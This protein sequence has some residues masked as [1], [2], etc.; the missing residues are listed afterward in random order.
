MLVLGACGGRT[1]IID[2]VD[3]VQWNGV[4][5]LHVMPTTTPSSDPVLG[6]R[7]AT[8]R[9]RLADNETDPSH[10][11]Q[12]GEAAFLQAGTPIYS[13][14]DYR[15]SFR[16]GV[17]GATGVAIYEADT[18]SRA[19]TGADLL[20]LEGKVVQIT[21]GDSSERELAAIRDPSVVGHLVGLLLQAP[22]DQSVHAPASGP[23]Y[24][25]TIRFL[26]GTH[27]VRAFWPSTGELSRGILAGPDFAR[28][29]LAT[30]PSPAA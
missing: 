21:V 8:T 14:R 5:Y 1:A 6:A 29:I 26:D 19:R 3:F 28:A 23:Q 22:V 9:R 18:N 4:T 11:P 27:T 12:D 15:S 20:D 7:V 17:K 10:R 16:I 30:L 25:L 24:F 13:L 2:W